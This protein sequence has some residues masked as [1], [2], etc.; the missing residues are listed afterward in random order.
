MKT[1]LV[2]FLSILLV[3]TSC[4]KNKGSIS[5]T[6]NKASAVYGNI[7]E[8]RNT[9]LTSSAQTIVNSGKIFVGDDFLLIGE[10]DQGIHVFNNAN[11]SSPVAIG[12][13]NLPFTE[14]FYVEGDVIFAESHYDLV[15]ISI[16]DIYN[17]KLMD[18]V[19]YAFGSPMKNDD[20]EVL[21]GF[22][23]KVTTETFEL[24][25]PEAEELRESNYLYYNYMNELIP[26]SSVPSS[27]AGGGSEIKGTL[28]KIAVQN[29]FVYVIGNSTI[30]TFMD[31]ASGVQFVS[32]SEI[33]NE[34]ETI[35]AENNNLFIGTKFS[36]IIASISNPSN[37]TV[38]SEYSHPTSCDPV[39]PN[40]GVAYLTLRTADFSGCAGDE[41]SLVVLDISN[42]QSPQEIDVIT[43]DSPYG[44][45]LIGNNLFVGEGQNGIKIFDATNPAA[46]VHVI[47]N[48]SVLAYDI[49][50]HPTMTNIILTTGDSGLQQY[51]IDYS[52]MSMQLVSSINY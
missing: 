11:T 2:L 15:K 23:Y 34:M 48:V 38:I 40:G 16:A 52:D 39:Y 13:I 20:G 41:N 30:Y 47:S 29:G 21:M 17:P 5:M 1:T 10:K 4:V 42:V 7:D 25:S 44:I 22:D 27:F 31:D 35:Y 24:N 46:L 18:R 45:A 3:T 37:P 8:V 50:E 14:E 32:K 9:P 19:E 6:Y 51:E 36:M 28:N 33:G 26:Q 43:M 12:F 49:I